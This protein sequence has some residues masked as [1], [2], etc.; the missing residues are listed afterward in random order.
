METPRCPRPLSRRVPRVQAQGRHQEPPGEPG[1]AVLQGLAVLGGLY[2]LFL[3]ELLLGMLRR[4]REATVRAAGTGRARGRQRGRL[5][6]Q[7][8]RCP[9]GHPHGETLGLAAGVPAPPR[10]GT[11]PSHPPEPP[12]PAPVPVPAPTGA[13]VSVPPQGPS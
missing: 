2:L 8:L 10:G 6:T 12:A 3:L 7:R 9:Q 1:P 5:C 13:G 4:R 11:T